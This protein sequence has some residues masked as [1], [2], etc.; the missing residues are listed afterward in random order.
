MRI[1][2]KSFQSLFY[3]FHNIQSN[4]Q[5][6]APSF[7]GYLR[8]PSTGDRRN[9]GGQF[10]FQRIGFPIMVALGKAQWPAQAAAKVLDALAGRVGGNGDLIGAPEGT[11]LGPLTDQKPMQTLFTDERFQD[12]MW[13][14]AEAAVGPMPFTT[15]AP[16]AQAV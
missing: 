3:L 7:S 5:C 4:G 11:A 15:T 12:A 1:L 14:T 10:L 9:E 8:G 2:F 6:P 16:A 13:R